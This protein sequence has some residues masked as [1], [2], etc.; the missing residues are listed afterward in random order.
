VLTMAFIANYSAILKSLRVQLESDK[1]KTF[2][3]PSPVKLLSSFLSGGGSSNSTPTTVKGSRTPLM[4]NVPSM[5]PPALSRSS[6][7]KTDGDSG[8]RPTRPAVEETRPSNPLVRLEQTF[9]SYIAS[10]QSRKGNVLGKVLRNRS[11]ADELSVNALY[12][13]LIENPLDTRSASEVSVDVLFAAFEKFL[14]IAWKDQMGPVATLQTLRALQEKSLKLFPGDF[15]DYIKLLFGDMA[16]QNRRAFVAIVRLLADLLEGCGNDGDRG[17]LTAV[18]T[19]LLVPEGDAHDHINLLDRLVEDS[20]RLFDDL[21]PVV[22]N[23]LVTPMHGSISSTTRSTISAYTGSVTS[24]A[25]SFRKKFGFDALLRQN[26]KN[27]SDGKSSM[28]RTLSKSHRNPATGEPT[29]SSF[30]KASLAYSRSTDIDIRLG[31]PNK[32]PTSHDRPTL[33]G[34]FDNRPSSSHNMQ[35]GLSTVGIAPSS[36]EAGTMKS[37]K[38]K[39]RSSLSDL[40]TL[41]A[42][43]TLDS[44]P[45]MPRQQ[46]PLLHK[47]DLSPRTPSPTKSTTHQ[48]MTHDK[49]SQKG[50]GPSLTRSIGSLTERSQNITSADAAKV[51]LASGKSWNKT[52]LMSNIPT[53]NGIVRDRTPS[54]SPPLRPTNSPQKVSTQKLRLQ[55]A[56]KLRERLQHEAKEIDAAEESLQSELSKIGAEMARLN[57]GRTAHANPEDLQK[58]SDS[59][60]S[61]ESRIPTVVR[62]LT[63]RNNVIKRELET[64]LQ[65]SEYKVKGL[66]QLYKEV[67]AENE[68]LY[69]K[70]N[71]ELGKIVK[72]LK[73][74]GK[75]DKED[76]V[77]KTKEAMEEAARIKKENARLRREMLTLRTLLK[78]NV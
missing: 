29:S 53:L 1:L 15:A 61:L 13:K 68:L 62:D 43:A 8:D 60:K 71:G 41:M 23:G 7:Q 42:S 24:N 16:P 26:S 70:F 9:S 22:S 3:P 55:N 58:L 19:E 14:R 49:L 65:A 5:L 32:R 51:T 54:V 50:N 25:S 75:E 28:W 52:T 69:E 27:D 21:G 57:A 47:P 45:P 73:G 66:D 2:R 48:P 77:V 40:K 67:C 36:D 74:K 59:V 10:L 78:G 4:G 6:S 11:S 33:M 31:I 18:F 20:E 12:N 34:T 76:L 38:K 35:S 44:A 56:Q 30:S 72:A 37:L 17:A 39:R 46:L 63:S 64:T